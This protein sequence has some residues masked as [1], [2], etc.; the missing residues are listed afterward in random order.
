V[1]FTGNLL[2]S[3]GPPV[4]RPRRTFHFNGFY[5]LRKWRAAITSTLFGFP[6]KLWSQK[7]LASPLKLDT[8]IIGPRH[9][10]NMQSSTRITE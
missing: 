4:F 3:L 5:R 8:L 9:Q 2:F 7:M 1:Q 6:I 10:R